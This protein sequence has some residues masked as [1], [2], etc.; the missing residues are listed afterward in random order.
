M[1]LPSK[2]EDIRKMVFVEK[3]VAINNL[4][5][6]LPADVHPI[7]EKGQTIDPKNL[8]QTAPIRISL[9]AD[10]NSMGII[11]GQH[12][13]FAYYRSKQDTPEIESLRRIQNLLVTGIIY[14]EHVNDV[15]K[16]RFEAE[17]FLNINSNQTSASS[18]LI[19]EIEVL[20]DPFAQIS[21]AKQVME[22]LADSGPLAGHVERYFFEKGKLKTS[23][24]VSFGLAPLVK[25]TGADSLFTKFAHLEKDKVAKG[26]SK[27]IL[28]DYIDF[29]ANRIIELLN[30][31]RVNVDAKRWTTDKKV[32][33]RILTVTYVNSFLIVLR[34]AISS[35]KSIKFA[36][37]KTKFNGIDKFDFEKFHSSQ[38]NRMADEIF[39][40][41]LK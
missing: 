11:D 37:L 20:L 1:L 10:A 14:P 40:K 41:H 29:C 9:P 23:S 39:D 35:G 28:T 19:Q 17:L 5:A 31:V 24:I 3:R 32:S 25:L 33:G 15:E 16:D 18:D 38:Y 34:K 12:R 8:T 6:T 21:I 26:T 30:A 22:R 4:I 2:I 13:L 36:S 27:A 7:N